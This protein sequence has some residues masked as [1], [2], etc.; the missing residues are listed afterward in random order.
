MTQATR[1][2]L[3]IG[4]A[5]AALSLGLGAAGAL[6]GIERTAWDWRVRA[7]ARPAP[8][9]DAVALI[10][11]DQGSLDWGEQE[12]GLGWPWPR[13][14][15]APV[16]D[17]CRRGGASVVAFDIL[18]TE[19][20]TYGVEDDAALGAAVAD[21]GRFVGARTLVLEP[22]ALDAAPG[23]LPI[24]E[25]AGA[26]ARLANVTDT[27]DPD[28]VFRRAGLVRRL[29]GELI[30]SLGLAA[31]ML[32]AGA[33]APPEL[34]DGRL[35]VGDRAVPVAADG[36]A[37]LRYRGGP[38]TYPAYS[39]AAVIQSELRL[40]EGGA[41]TVDPELLRGRIVFVGYSAPGLKD[42]R[43]T[44]LSPTAPGAVVHATVA[45]DLL[46]DDF[47]TPVPALPA[48]L[49]VLLAAVGA[50]L[51]VTR[52]PDARRGALGAALALLAP[53]GLGLATYAAGLGWPVVPLQAAVAASVLGGFV[54]NYA[55]EGRQ[56]RFLKTAFRHYLSPAVIER[57]LVDPDALKLGGERRELT[58]MFSDLAGFTSL[59]EG[60]DPEALTTLLN[61]YLTDMTDIIL[62]E[63][64]TLDKYEGD[65]ILA[66]WNAPLAQPD[67][68]ERACRAAVRCQR[69]L[70]ERRPE[71]RAR[72]G[73]DL[74]MRVG[75]HT[76]EVVVGN[77]GS[78]Q[79]F[80]YTVLGDA[81][82]LA[83]R[84]EGANKAFG[85]ATMISG[86]TLAAAAGAVQVRD[87]G[88]A[89][90]VGRKEPVPVHE[91]TGLAG[92]APPP[93]HPEFAAALARLRAGELDA[94]A[95]AFA[96][97]ADR[98]AVAAVFARRCRE[99]LDAGEPFT[100]HWNLTSK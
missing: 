97:L 29:D 27:P 50:A 14:V 19:A 30:P 67:H 85:S 38:G 5:A 45:D 6:D 31:W 25:V 66:F 71:F 15:W 13:Q 64:G 9:T 43:A 92:D 87:L 42:L 89:A 73:R 78:R 55:T 96:A 24:D 82:N 46:A 18:F 12:N 98:D 39:V 17:F 91:L 100:G 80:D 3:L 49:T 56:R 51:L 35:R 26:A 4:M 99:A 32:H 33:D 63:G 75:L 37:L 7:L 8:T 59:S 72:C 20:S 10:L 2:G 23:A 90:V 52:T 83:S 60:L 86:A 11:L 36:A 79:R 76:G 68:A 61:D 57:I 65:A 40:L 58:I 77:M 69:R 41:P 16:L 53:A 28:G 1:H 93:G 62:E 48:A 47:L 34:R 22:G 88:T 70:A 94:A 54:R 84:L 95:A 44:P 74:T 21:Q 81:A